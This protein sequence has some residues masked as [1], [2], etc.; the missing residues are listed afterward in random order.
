MQTTYVVNRFFINDQ[1]TIVGFIE[2][3][4]MY[5][6]VLL[7]MTRQVV[8]QLF[9]YTGSVN[10]RLYARLSFCQQGQHGFIYVIIDQ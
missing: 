3:M 7:V 1:E 2:S 10:A 8:F 4:C 5:G 9:G 6:R